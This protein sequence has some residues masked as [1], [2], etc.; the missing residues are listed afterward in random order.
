VALREK[1]DDKQFWRAWGQDLNFGDWIWR[2]KSFVTELIELKSKADLGF[3]E[4]Q[5]AD[6]VASQITAGKRS[7]FR[8]Q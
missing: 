5:M 4:Q 7:G 6:V 1:Q 3:G 2:L 8:S